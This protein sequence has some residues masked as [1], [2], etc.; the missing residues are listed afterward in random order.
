MMVGVEQAAIMAQSLL[1]LDFLI[2]MD[3][4]QIRIFYDS[5]KHKHVI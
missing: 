5:M 2:L 1:E 4:S 3:V